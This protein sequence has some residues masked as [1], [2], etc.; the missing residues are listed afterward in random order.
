MAKMFDRS[1]IKT[2]PLESRENK[3]F[4]KDFFSLDYEPPE[5]TNKDLDI[6]ADRI[7]SARVKDKPVIWMMGAHLIR[8]GNSL[9]VIDLIKKGVI[10]HIATNGACAIHDFEFAYMNATCEDVERYVKD[11]QF[12]NW[13]ETGRLINNAVSDGYRYGLGFGESVG[14]MINLSTKHR[15]ISVFAYACMK[16]I[17]ITVHKSIGQDITDQHPSADYEALGGASGRDFLIFAETISKL[18]GGGVFLNL[19]TQVMGPEVYL[20]A[21]SMARNVA[22]QNG[23]K[24]TDFITAVFDIREDPDYFFRPKKTILERTVKDGGESF[25]IQG[26]FALTTPHLY[27]KIVEKL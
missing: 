16:G 21:L 24:I 18:E 1:R 7:V 15:D 8:R 6:L 14:N 10:T 5:Y 11:G 12:G 27:R 3:H 23:W 17:P 22:N 26:D 19:G 2:N 13:E 4:V 9:F 20:K 25:Y